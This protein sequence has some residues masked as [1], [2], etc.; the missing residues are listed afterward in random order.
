LASPSPATTTLKRLGPV[1]EDPG[2]TLSD[3]YPPSLEAP[4]AALIARYAG[5]HTP[6]IVRQRLLE[7]HDRLAGSARV[8]DFLPIFAEREVR[9]EL[10]RAGV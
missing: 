8:P 2:V 9:S 6:E 1:S 3:P 10:D 5:R 7:V 4:A